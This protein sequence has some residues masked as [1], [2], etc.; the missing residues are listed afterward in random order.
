MVRSI[1]VSNFNVRHLDSLLKSAKIRPAVNQVEMHPYLPQTDLLQ[2]C[3]AHGIALTAYSPLGMGKPTNEPNSNVPVLLEDPVV[4]KVAKRIGATPAQVLLGWLL[5]QGVAVIP[6]S[7][8]PTRIAENMAARPLEAEIVDEISTK[9]TTR[10]RYCDPLK[11]WGRT[12]F[13]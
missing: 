12:C 4:E 1:G 2:Y 7:T 8:N 3:R 9:I 6:R 13:D 5:G 11:W 10:Y